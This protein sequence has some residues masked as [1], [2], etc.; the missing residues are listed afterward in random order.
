MEK[1]PGDFCISKEILDVIPTDPHDLLDLARKIT[2]MAIASRVKHLDEEVHRLHES[3]VEKD[4]LID[5]LRLRLV[6]MDKLFQETEARLKTSLEENIKLSKER[7]S[8]VMSTKKLSRELSKLEAFKRHLMQSLKEEDSPTT[9]SEMVDIGTCDQD[10]SRSSGFIDNG[11]SAA[12]NNALDAQVEGSKNVA[13]KYSMVP[14]MSPKVIPKSRI[15]STATSP[16]IVS[17]AASPTKQRLEP[18]VP[19]SPWYSSSQLSSATNSPPR[20][21]PT[22]GRPGRIDGKEFFRQTRSRLSYEQFAAFLANIKELN[23]HRQSREET[24]KKAEE[25]FGLDNKDLYLSFQG[26]LNRTPS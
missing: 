16:K 4:G 23:A 17:G 14:F 26:L 18:Q 13:Q 7:D 24:L 15:H 12:A 21:R 5:E 11:S 1:N 6:H 25:I 3:V 2:S 10:T 8:L 19:F 9:K 20:S 22:T